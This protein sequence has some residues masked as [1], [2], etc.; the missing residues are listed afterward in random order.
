MHFDLYVPR[1]GFPLSCDPK[2]AIV[3][4]PARQWMEE[5]EARIDGRSPKMVAPDTTLVIDYEGNRYG[6]VNMRTYADRATHAAGRQKEHY[7]TVARMIVPAKRLIRVA[8]LDYEQEQVRCLDEDAV[9]T[10]MKWLDVDHPALQDEL[11]GTTVRT[12]RAARAVADG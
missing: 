10:L 7:P 9:L 12:I 8:T 1:E 5:R 6:A 11:R 3:G 2:S 4:S